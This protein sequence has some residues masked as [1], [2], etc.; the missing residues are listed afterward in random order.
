MRKA[1]YNT[2]EYKLASREMQAWAFTH[3][4]HYVS[5]EEAAR[6]MGV[7]LDG[8]TVKV[9]CN[10]GVEREVDVIV[11]HYS[12]LPSPKY[13][14]IQTLI[15]GKHQSV[16][17]IKGSSLKIKNPI[18]FT[19]EDFTKS[20]DFIDIKNEIDDAFKRYHDEHHE[21]LRAELRKSLP[22]ITK[23]AQAELADIAKERGEEGVY[24]WFVKNG[25]KMPHVKPSDFKELVKSLK[26][27]GYV[28]SSWNVS[29][30][31]DGWGHQTGTNATIDWVKKTIG[32]HD[33][34]S[35]D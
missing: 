35:D 16:Y 11:S 14:L 9:K 5:A 25:F 4:G 26:N 29:S 15:D 23:R 7:K 22:S 28:I 18:Y 19:M 2:P 32:M 31:P 6:K 13:K 8:R 10:D 27:T 33:W 24:E 21:M 30:R 1:I 20:K 12:I 34:S 17:M 3:R